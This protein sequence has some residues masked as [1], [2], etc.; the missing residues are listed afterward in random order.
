MAPSSNSTSTQEPNE[1]LEF[2]TSTH[3]PIKL[4][5]SNY[6]A[7]YKQIDSL[8]VAHGLMG[9]VIFPVIEYDSSFIVG[10]WHFL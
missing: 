2:N 7:W 6:P 4:N 3:L 8:L 1:L 9:Y 10:S 5:S